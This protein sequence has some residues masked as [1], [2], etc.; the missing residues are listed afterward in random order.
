M[1]KPALNPL[2]IANEFTRV[3]EGEEYI[4]SQ[5][6]VCRKCKGILPLN[7]QNVE[8]YADKENRI[9]LWQHKDCNKPDKTY[10]DDGSSTIILDA[11]EKQDFLYGRM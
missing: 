4:V 10:M 8:E 6:R 7:L 3:I 1:K 2:H 9:I 11:T 5:V